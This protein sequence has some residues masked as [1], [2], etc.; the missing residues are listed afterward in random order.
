MDH[1]EA[2]GGL[3]FQGQGGAWESPLSSAFF[4]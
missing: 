2:Q 1:R 3:G 4:G